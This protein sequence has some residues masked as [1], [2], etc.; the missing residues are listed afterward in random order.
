M[1]HNISSPDKQDRGQKSP[2]ADSSTA[3]SAIDLPGLI[4]DDRDIVIYRPFHRFSRPCS[5]PMC[6]PGDSWEEE[7]SLSRLEFETA[8]GRIA[9]RTR[10]NLVDDALVSCWTTNGHITWYAFNEELLVRR[11]AELYPADRPAA[12]GMQT[13]FPVQPMP[14]SGNSVSGKRQG[15]RCPR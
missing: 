9:V 14:E 7:L 1:G 3:T 10:G 15:H 8:R 6:R 11:P 12:V 5:Q 4:A 2:A 13:A